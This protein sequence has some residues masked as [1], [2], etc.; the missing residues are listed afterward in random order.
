MIAMLAVYG[1]IESVGKAHAGPVVKCD[2]IEAEY[3]E[4]VTVDGLS[5]FATGSAKLYSSDESGLFEAIAQAR[6]HAKLI[7]KN[8]ARV[9]KTDHGLL[10]GV[11]VGSTCMLHNTIFCTISVNER[12]ARQAA[13]LQRALSDI[14]PSVE[15]Y[16]SVSP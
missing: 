6:L 7:L 8:N 15:S 2:R 13:K 3:K 5:F 9:P 11:L 10:L 1:F 4:V 14:R 12:T 16:S